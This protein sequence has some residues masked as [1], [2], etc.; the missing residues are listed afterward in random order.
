MSKEYPDDLKYTKEHEWARIDG[1]RA[2]IG[3]TQFAADELTDITFV[4]LPKPGPE[5]SFASDEYA[6]SR[7]SP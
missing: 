3:I 2:T 5:I 4:Q 7:M 1:N 6:T